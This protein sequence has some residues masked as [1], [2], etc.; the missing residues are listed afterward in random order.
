M[1]LYLP[2]VIIRLTTIRASK[3]IV[4]K[5]ADAV[6]EGRAKWKEEHGD[7][8]AKDGEGGDYAEATEKDEELL[9][10]ATLAKLASGAYAEE[11]PE[12]AASEGG[13]APAG[14]EA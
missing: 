12:A 14:E 11:K 6:I 7:E 8:P 9:G 3:L 10:A 2:V 4:G 5:M 13:E 1:H